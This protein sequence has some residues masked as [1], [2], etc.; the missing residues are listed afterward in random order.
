MLT[1]RNIRKSFSGVEVLHGV[2]F[3]VE[4][5]KVV[6][7]VGENGAG[8]STLMKILSGAITDYQGEII[9][10]GCS[11][12][13]TSPRDAE[14]A[15]IS[16][17]YQELNL[18]PD[19]SVAENIF[20]G[21]EPLRWGGIIDFPELRRKA[22]E[23]L[24]EF[25]FPF[26]VTIKLRHLPVGWQQMVEIARAVHRDA[27]IF[28]MDEPTS[29]LSEK[30]IR[31]LFEK[32]HYL[33]SLG[34]TVIYITHRMKEVF[35]IAEEVVVLRDGQLVGQ[36][37]IQRINPR[38]LVHLMV[39]KE[40]K[41][42]SLLPP[43]AE[44]PARLAV[45]KLSFRVEER[46][47]LQ[48]LTFEVKPGEVLGI[49][50]L[51]GAGRTELLKFLY[52]ELSGAAEGE[53][54]LEGRLY[55]PRSANR[56]LRRKIV[57]L[58]E[59]RKREGIFPDLSVLFNSTISSLPKFSGKLFIGKKSEQQAV[60]AMLQELKVRFHSLSQKIV[61]L[62][63]GNQQKVLIGRILLL[64]PRLLLLDEPTRGVDV[65]AKQ[66]I[67]QIIRELARDGMS[68]LMTSSEI[69][70]LFQVCHRILVLARGRAVKILST[71]Q[72][73]PQEILNYAFAT[74]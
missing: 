60:L 50:G 41:E 39:G 43:R 16:T 25:N 35:E 14:A 73:N 11:C 32:I 1:F 15:G 38:W 71:S 48:N 45:R 72:T 31:F 64:Q 53:V 3:S 66:E 55:R 58:S 23:I 10:N 37:P 59:D 4:P 51:L 8:K 26:P 52:G 54:F 74:E 7:L 47:V 12:R 68:I 63:G 24:R 67:Y 49:A 22:R 28:I 46:P 29:A 34:K 2:S 27:S 19:L 36:F 20:L 40:V 9:L 42:V 6:A 44:E 30:E 65:Q 70:E 5:G 18:I 17:I 56:S 61:T 21:K 57:Y 13:F 62:S 33:K 69:P